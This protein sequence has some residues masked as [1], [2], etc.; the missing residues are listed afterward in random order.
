MDVYV[1]FKRVHAVPPV[2]MERHALITTYFSR[3]EGLDDETV[4]RSLAALVRPVRP[5]SAASLAFG[6][7]ATAP[8]PV[9]GSLGF[10]YGQNCAV[11]HKRCRSRLFV[12][13]SDAPKG[14]VMCG[15]CGA[16]GISAP[17]VP[18]A[19]PIS[20]GRQREAVV[21]PV[22]QRAP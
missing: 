4:W 15:S 17:S 5:R 21:R 7:G 1:P 19:L 13:G 12:P 2:E 18:T 6:A 8:V 11:C 9:G 3:A 20:R 10:N 14:P 22:R 16:Q